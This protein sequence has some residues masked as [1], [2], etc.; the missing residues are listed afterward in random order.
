VQVLNLGVVYKVHRPRARTQFLWREVTG[1]LGGEEFSV[2]Y[3]EE[4]SLEKQGWKKTIGFRKS[5]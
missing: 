5:F 4:Q 3:T 1:W 2:T